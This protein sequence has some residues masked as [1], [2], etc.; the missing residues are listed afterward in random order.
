M[1]EIILQLIMFWMPLVAI[2]VI[3]FGVGAAAVCTVGQL[4]A[5]GTFRLNRRSVSAAILLP[6]LMT[7]WMIRWWMSGTGVVGWPTMVLQVFLAGVLAGVLIL[8][9]GMRDCG[10]GRFIT[11][12]L[13]SVVALG[14]IVAGLPDVLPL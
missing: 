6:L 10:R 14:G 4:I 2:L 7:F 3:C 9:C 8:S 1:T 13:A 5:S 12:A 11:V